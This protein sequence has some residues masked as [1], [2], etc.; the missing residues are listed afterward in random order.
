VSDFGED[1]LR[2]AARVVVRR[3]LSDLVARGIGTEEDLTTAFRAWLDR[4]SSLTMGEAALR[5]R[6]EVLEWDRQ[7]ASRHGATIRT[8]ETEGA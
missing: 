5:F 7:R 3:H 8:L 2:G 4:N 6:L 1:L